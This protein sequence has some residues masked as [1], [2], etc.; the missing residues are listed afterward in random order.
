MFTEKEKLWDR[1]SFKKLVE[2][3]RKKDI[4]VF[5]VAIDRNSW[6]KFLFITLADIHRSSKYTFYSLGY[7]EYREKYYTDEWHCYPQHRNG[8]EIPL[9][10]LKVVRVI[11]NRFEKIKKLVKEERRTS[12]GA[13]FDL[14]ADNS[15]DDFAYSFLNG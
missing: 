11:R 3:I 7:H 5:E 15:D 13:M 6:G 2:L 1:V 10:K 4:Q 9:D 12:H 14:I 8:N